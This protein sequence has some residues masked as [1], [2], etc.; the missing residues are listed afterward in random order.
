[1]TEKKAYIVKDGVWV[2]EDVAERLGVEGVRVEQMHDLD[3]VA[4]RV[5][6]ISPE[7]A[8]AIREEFPER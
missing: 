7:R 5:L 4:H 6:N 8:K 3:E 1:M 2:E